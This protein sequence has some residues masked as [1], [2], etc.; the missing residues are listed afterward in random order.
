MLKN[1]INIKT[2]RF[3][4]KSKIKILYI[5]IFNTFLNRI[6]GRNSANSCVSKVKY[7][8]LARLFKNIGKNVNFQPNIRIEGWHNITIGDFSGLGRNCH[9]T[10][11]STVKI[12]DNVMIAE[13]VI[14]NTANHMISSTKLMMNLPMV[15]KP[16]QIGNNV[17]IGARVIIL[18]GV[19]IEDNI[20]I[21]AGAVVTKSFPSNCIIGGVPAKIIKHIL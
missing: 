6:E 8:Y 21:A 5:F 9:V 7:V 14:I 12:G 13:D 1:R 18:S 4:F 11:L 2:I 17:W 16:I 3:A 20:V 15:T 10:A 19:K